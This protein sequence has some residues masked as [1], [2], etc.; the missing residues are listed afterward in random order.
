[1]TKFEANQAHIKSLQ[2]QL[3]SGKIKPSD[4]TT[5]QMTSIRQSIA[6]PGAELT[7]F[8]KNI[9]KS[10]YNFKGSQKLLERQINYLAGKQNDYF[11]TGMY[12]NNPSL[13]KIMK[14]APVNPNEYINIYN[15]NP[16]I[17]NYKNQN[18]L[19]Q[20]KN[21]LTRNL[22]TELQLA[23]R[24]ESALQP[25]TKA[26]KQTSKYVFKTAGTDTD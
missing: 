6:E 15:R 9:N 5:A 23:R 2:D 26:V 25:T 17:S 19:N 12:K 1:M 24:I 10:K 14:D 3:F 16:L 7:N 4:L 11:L 8:V 20:Q 22:N 21:T 13:Q 18:L